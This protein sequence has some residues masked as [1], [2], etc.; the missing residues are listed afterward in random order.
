MDKSLQ[1]S[2]TRKC[3]QLH[4]LHIH[5]VT[6]EPFLRLPSP[7]EN[8]IVTPPR[9]S[10]IPAIVE[11]LNDLR[12]YRWLEG[13]P[14]P[15]TTDD[16]DFWLRKV[17]DSSD[18]VL[19]QLKEAGDDTTQGALIVGSCPVRALREVQGDGTELYLGEI[20]VDRCGYPDM[21]SCPE[22]AKLVKEN[23]ERDPGD[24]EIVWCI[25]GGVHL[26]RIPTW[27]LISTTLRLPCCFSP[28]EMYYVRCAWDDHP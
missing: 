4:P 1:P 26:P 23:S 22:K 8:V 25:G 14:F 28:W 2:M 3:P 6:G 12:V 11:N 13:P 21:N 18:A 5:P 20:N 10:D 27:I 16:G 24:P 9:I 15:Y 19:Q 7:H 17:K